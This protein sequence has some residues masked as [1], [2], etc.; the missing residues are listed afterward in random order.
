MKHIFCI[1]GIWM[2]SF[3]GAAQ[4]VDNNVSNTNTKTKD[5]FLETEILNE[6]L[7]LTIPKVCLD[8]PILWTRIG[9][10]NRYD[11]KQVTF[12]RSSDKIVMDE[13]RIWSEA[14]IWIP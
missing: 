14:G 6:R 3:F 1:L 4:A 7:F 10:M 9:D 2:M 12:K 5:P 8:K 13:S 11:Y